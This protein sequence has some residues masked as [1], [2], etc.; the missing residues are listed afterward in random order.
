MG[1]ARRLREVQPDAGRAPWRLLRDRNLDG[2]KF[3]RQPPIPP[4]IADFCCIAHR[5]IV[6]LDG[7]QHTPDSDAVRTRYLSRHGWRVLRFWDHDVPTHPDA[8]VHVIRGAVAAPNPHPNPSPAG[9]G[10]KVQGLP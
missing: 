7:S 10:A 1:R 5:L 4:C 3:R 2:L 8:V 6:E 9:R